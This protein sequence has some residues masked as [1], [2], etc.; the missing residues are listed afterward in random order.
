[1]NADADAVLYSLNHWRNSSRM[2]CVNLVNYD[3]AADCGACEKGG[4]EV[5][6]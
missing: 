2:T 1:M 4:R 3:R 6:L 5:Y